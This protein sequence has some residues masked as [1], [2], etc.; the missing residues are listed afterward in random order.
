MRNNKLLLF[1]DTKLQCA[2]LCSKGELKLYVT[3]NKR[4]PEAFKNA[5]QCKV[6]KSDL[7]FKHW[8]LEERGCS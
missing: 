5:I 8:S 7:H 1:Q 4:N 2:L 3:E 6:A